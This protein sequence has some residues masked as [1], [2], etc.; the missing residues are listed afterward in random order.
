MRRLVV[1]LAALL[2]LPLVA[3]SPPLA[4]QRPTGPP[5]FEPGDTEGLVVAPNPR[6]RH[7]WKR[8]VFWKASYDTAV[9]LTRGIP[10]HTAAERT[11][12]IAVL[13]RLVAPLKATP[14]GTS[15]EGFWVSDGRVLDYFDQFALPEKTPLARFPLTFGTGLYPFRHEDIETNG[16]WRLS[17][18][19]ETESVY[20]EFNRLPE[21][22][23]QPP[24]FTEPAVGDRLPEPLYLR[25]RVTGTWRGLP[26]YE[27]Q[28]LV[29]AREGR[30][31]WAPVPMAR[32]L[33]AA[34]GLLAQD[35]TTA[36]SRLAGY[37]RKRDEVMAPEWEQQKRA[38]FETQ[39]GE[40]RTSR[41]SNYGARLRSL[42]HEIEV[43][44]QQAQADA[45]PQ[46]DPKGLWYWNPLEAYDE[47]AAR[48]A[49]LSGEAANEPACVVELPD[50]ETGGRYTFK[51]RIVAER[52]A[53]GCRP[54]VR[55]NWA[56][57]DLSL[58]RTAPQILL[59]PDFGRCARVAGDELV[60]QPVSRW[61]APPQGCVQHAQMW[62]EADWTAMASLVVP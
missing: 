42:E 2:A 9:N 38:T 15:G 29:V 13:D 35:R 44:R 10:P 22:V 47:A 18:A 59:V 61:D 46:H 16:T 43:T 33:K 30:D 3:L 49:A 52:E 24:V 45:D 8:K 40:L 27:Q 58:P 7:A 23:R 36:E 48:L 51:G 41:P 11:A 32:A 62:R 4:A 25:P 6:I 19:G 55:T 60:S 26:V 21:S 37:R 12:M 39:N 53:P 28:A 34:L 31:P 17:V 56:Y 1:V 50:R 5:T 54:L 20:F 57:F 14:T